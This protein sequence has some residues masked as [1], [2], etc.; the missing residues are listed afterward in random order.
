MAEVQ[1]LIPRPRAA[2]PQVTVPTLVIHS[3]ND[4]FVLPTNA[5]LLV[6]ELGAR[7][8]R[9]PMIEGSNHLITLDAARQQ[10]FEEHPDVRAASRRP[11][12]INRDLR[13]IALSLLIW[14]FGEGMFI[15]FQPVYLHELGADPVQIGGIL[16]LAAL[17]M[18]VSHIPAGALADPSGAKA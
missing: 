13:L 12:A 18:L 9:L 7:D 6:A 11:A 3:R 16:G 5:E 4:K 15:Y 17:G 8:K 14:G 1:D 10:V 2:L